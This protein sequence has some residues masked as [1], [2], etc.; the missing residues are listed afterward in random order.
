MDFFMFYAYLFFFC[1]VYQ[2]IVFSVSSGL[3]KSHSI[4]VLLYFRNPDIEKRIHGNIEALNL[5]PQGPDILTP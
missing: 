1:Y 4:L 2:K 3:L 5:P